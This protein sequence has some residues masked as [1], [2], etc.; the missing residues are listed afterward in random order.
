MNKK[1]VQKSEY[2]EEKDNKTRLDIFAME[3]FNLTRN[4]AQKLINERLIKVNGD[5]AKAKYILQNCDEITLE[6]IEKDTSGLKIPV[7]YEDKDILVINK[8]SGI[9]THPA[10]G[11]KE[12]TVS[13]Y[14]RS[15]LDFKA[16]DERNGVV[17]RLDKGTSGVMILA[18]NEKTQEILKKDFKDRKI[19][20]TYLALIQG[21]IEPKAGIINIP[22]GRDNINKE[23]M[24]VSVEGKEAITVFATVNLYEKYSLLKINPK[25]GRTHQIRVHMASLG[26]PIVGD[27][28][29]GKPT[30]LI[31]RIFLH[32]SHIEFCHPI[33]KKEMEFEASLPPELDTILN[34]LK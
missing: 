9:S 20:K 17:H 23:K 11:E 28:R 1:I 14:F 19:Q 4:K 10:P 29:Y 8:P 25:T 2:R 12:T 33:T 24:S 15:K 34:N 32:A 16:N 13:E 3:S 22:I 6:R 5:Q 7:V 27:K 31:N 21:H 30:T 26:H 18:K